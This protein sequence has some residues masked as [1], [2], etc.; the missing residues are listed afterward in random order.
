MTHSTNSGILIGSVVVKIDS[1]LVD[2]LSNEA[3]I[4]YLQ[5]PNRK[6]EFDTD[7]INQCLEAN[8]IYALR[9]GKSKELI[10]THNIVDLT[11]QN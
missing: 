9:K 6:F 4:K 7:I 8:S 10:V 5:E 2:Q 3:I 11:M 1:L